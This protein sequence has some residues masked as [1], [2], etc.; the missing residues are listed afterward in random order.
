MKLRAHIGNWCVTAALVGL[1]IVAAPVSGKAR[2]EIILGAATSLTFLEGRESLNA[3]KLAVA[4]INARGGVRMGDRSLQI[5]I[6]PMDLRGAQPGVPATE[7]L[8]RLERTITRHRVHAIVVGPF[9]SEVLLAG[10][11]IIAR[12]KIP[13]LGS[14]AMSPASDAKILRNSQYRYIFR[15]CLN[16]KYLVDYLIKTMKFLKIQY[17]FNKVYIVNQDVAWARTTASLMARLYFDRSDWIILGQDN[18]SS[19]VTDFAESL[20][21]AE[22]KGAQVILPI[23]DMPE[24]GK[25]VEQWYLRRDKSLMCGFISPMV[26]PEAWKT[27]QGKIEGSLNVI[28][29]LGNISSA[30]WQPSVD[31]YNAYKAKFGRAIQAGHGPAPAYESVYI[32]AAA[33]E[34][35]GTLDAEALVAALEA[36]DRIGAMGRIRF[37]RG[38][39]AFFGSDPNQDALACIFQWQK[40]GGRKIVYPL[41]VASGEIVVPGTR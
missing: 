1:M 38:H 24:S 36:T 20:A 25:L 3:V 2:D 23:F 33:I 30:R 19:G 8:S 41:S 11:D 22:S 16:A 31:F 10:M 4:Q 14:I 37:N 9:R 12:H 15:T 35:A 39:Q 27:F 40:D 5:R 18:Y 6:V 28:F 7:A 13:M 34:R 21:K 17:G 26:G 29:E 32:L